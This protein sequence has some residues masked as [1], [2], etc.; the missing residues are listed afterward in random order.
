MPVKQP[1]PGELDA[2]ETA[3][4]DE[5]T[6]LQLTRLK[7][8]L[9]H[10]YANV[11]HYRQAFDA[12]GVHPDD[13]K[14][15]ADLAKFPFTVKKDLR[16]NY[17]F[18]L[19]AVPREQAERVVVAQVGLARERQLRQVL[20]LAHV[21]GVHPGR[22]PRGAVVR[23]VGVGV[24]D[25]GPEPLGLQRPE[26]VERRLLDRVEVSHAHARQPTLGGWTRAPA[27]V[28]CSSAALR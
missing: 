21:V 16:D 6:A 13:L 23:D 15:L 5:V 3:S 22:V 1:T 24:L 19:F 4:R 20:E 11:P 28:A 7:A 18:G 17:P 14:S 25:R 27:D 26:L 2:I 9:H 12:K 8:T 10:A